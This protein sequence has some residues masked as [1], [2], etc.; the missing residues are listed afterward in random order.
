MKEMPRNSRSG[1]DRDVD[2]AGARPERPALD[3]FLDRALRSRASGPAARLGIRC[4]FLLAG[5]LVLAPVRHAGAD[6]GPE[7]RAAL[8]ALRRGEAA[9]RDAAE[10]RLRA[11]DCI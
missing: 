5:L 8:R 1:G 6:P 3:R 7:L 4:G 11:G 9:A 10:A 2:A